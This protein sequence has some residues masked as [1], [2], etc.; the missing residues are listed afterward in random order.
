MLDLGYL[1]KQPE[2]LQANRKLSRT[3]GAVVD[4]LERRHGDTLYQKARMLNKQ[5][6]A[7]LLNKKKSG[8]NLGKDGPG[9][10]NKV[11]RP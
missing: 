2:D 7:P 10:E 6:S 9:K 5:L 1:V 3:L 11:R 4:K 8:S